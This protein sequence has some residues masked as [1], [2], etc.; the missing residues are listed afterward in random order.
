MPESTISQMVATAAEYSFLA[1][2]TV[3]EQ[4]ATDSKVFKIMDI[5]RWSEAIGEREI[6]ASNRRFRAKVNKS[7]WLSSAHERI[8]IYCT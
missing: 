3:T 6:K 5:K 2:M 1:R 8:I 4:E 7:K